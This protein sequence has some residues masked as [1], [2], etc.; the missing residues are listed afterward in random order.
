M[1]T[2]TV[3]SNNNISFI[4]ETVRQICHPIN[5]LSKNFVQPP[6]L[7]KDWNKCLDS[8]YG[9]VNIGIEQN[10]A[11]VFHELKI[12]EVIPSKAANMDI[13]TYGFATTEIGK[14]LNFGES[15][16]K[17]KVIINYYSFLRLIDILLNSQDKEYYL[18]FNTSLNTIFKDINPSTFW[19]NFIISEEIAEYLKINNIGEVIVKEGSKKDTV[20]VKSKLEK[21]KSIWKTIES[22]IESN[23]ENKL[24]ISDDYDEYNDNEGDDIDIIDDI[25]ED[26]D[27]E[28]NN[29]YLDKSKSYLSD[30]ENKTEI[31]T[32]DYTEIYNEPISPYRLVM[33]NFTLLTLINY[34]CSISNN[35]NDNTNI[36]ELMGGDDDEF[37]SLF[38]NLQF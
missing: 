24:D 13:Y 3:M 26:S 37:T 31:T 22:D 25:Y 34:A 6:V 33:N 29:T 21:K 9:W 15:E 5:G 30:I 23:I 2:K 17:Y 28:K 7:L 36:Y 14:L 20:N 38:G 27:T 16:K 12:G 35:T 8:L 18:K 11:N 4:R 19:L 1:N 32:D 10:V